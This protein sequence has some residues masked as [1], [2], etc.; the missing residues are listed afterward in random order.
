MALPITGASAALAAT[1]RAPP[2]APRTAEAARKFQ[3][4]ILTEL[5]RPLFP[6]FAPLGSISSSSGNFATE[7]VGYLFGE[8]ITGKLAERDPFGLGRL[9]Q[10]SAGHRHGQAV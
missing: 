10:E 8:A 2:A 1:N 6:H 4:T 3:A 9:V 5:M 7:V